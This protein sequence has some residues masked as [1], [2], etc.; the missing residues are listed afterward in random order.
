M[1]T[2]AFH[3]LLSWIVRHFCPHSFLF[4][5]WL[6][7]FSDS[8]FS[9]GQQ[10]RKETKLVRSNLKSY[11]L[12]VLRDL[13]ISKGFPDAQQSE[14]TKAGSTQELWKITSIFRRK[15]IL[16]YASSWSFS[17]EFSDLTSSTRL[18]TN[19]KTSNAIR[20]SCLKTH[21][22]ALK[23]LWINLL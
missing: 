19:S 1:L 5:T 7:S 16:E 23:L 22:F 17:C 15:L 6:S 3:S 11:S 8:L 4:H 2:A 9:A 12:F 13:K 21:K 10:L 14:T 20:T 18:C